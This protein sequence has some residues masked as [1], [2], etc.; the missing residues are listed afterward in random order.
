[1]KAQKRILLIDD[2]PDNRDLI[3]FVLKKGGYEV[4]ETYNGV[5]G[6]DLAH[7]EMP[8]M[9]LL[10]LAMPEMDGWEVA[11]RLKTD[12]DTKQIKIVALTV[13]TLA[14]DRRQAIEAG[15]DGYLTKPIS[16]NTFIDDVGRFLD[17]P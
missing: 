16:V 3:R 13:R 9:V 1:M 17:E 2:D 15:V 12:P 5:I 10:D 6:I 11:R 8:D 7:K 14:E 4:L